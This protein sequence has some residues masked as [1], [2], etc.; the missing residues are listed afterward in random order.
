MSSFVGQRS[1]IYTGTD[2]VTFPATKAAAAATVTGEV[3]YP[4]E[5]TGWGTANV[6]LST[7]D[8]SDITDTMT[9]KSYVSFDEGTTWDQVG[10][11]TDLASG[12]TEALVAGKT[13][14]FAPRLRFDIVF[15]GSAE[16]AAG[17]GCNVAVEFV[18]LE[19]HRARTEFIEN[20][21]SVVDGL[22][23]NGDS[24][25]GDSAAIIVASS[26]LEVDTPRFINF[27][28]T[29][30]DL[31]KFDAVPKSVKYQYSIDGTN[32]VHGDSLG[33]TYSPQTTGSGV[34]TSKLY[35]IDSKTKTVS[36]YARFVLGGDSADTGL[37]LTAGHGLKWYVFSQE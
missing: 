34:F 37:E 5:K 13:I 12:D 14:P 16:L 20:I 11:Y 29:A 33:S 36:K 9:I 2:V 23:T 31:S 35:T 8:R 3:L 30:D 10:N 17:H 24:V 4:F 18:E 7:A 1:V 19:P 27:M 25:V 22:G 32:W 26:A 21:A 15:D 28:A 6:V